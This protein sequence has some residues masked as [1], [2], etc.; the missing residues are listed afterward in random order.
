M[1]QEFEAKADQE[2]EKRLNSIEEAYR[3]KPKH[4]LSLEEK[5]LK[6]LQSEH[7]TMVDE[8]DIIKWPTTK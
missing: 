4:V 6:E 2:E 3:K 7:P 5:T 1:K 8:E